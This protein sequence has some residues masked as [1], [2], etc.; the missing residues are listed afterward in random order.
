MSSKLKIVCST[1]FLSQEKATDYEIYI[2]EMSGVNDCTSE[3]SCFLRADDAL[4]C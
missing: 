2:Y 4:G 1:K 3:M